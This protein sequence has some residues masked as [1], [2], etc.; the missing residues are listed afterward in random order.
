MPPTSSS[1][2]SLGITEATMKPSE[3]TTDA[4]MISGELTRRPRKTS[5]SFSLFVI[6]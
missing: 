6:I 1:S 3:L 5:L 4:P 2:T